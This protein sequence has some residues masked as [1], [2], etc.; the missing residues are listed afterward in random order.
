MGKWHPFE[1]IRT[2]LMNNPPVVVFFLCMVLMAAAFIGFGAYTKKHD[3]RDP[4]VTQVSSVY[5]FLHIHVRE[6]CN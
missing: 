6:Q 4:D 5:L 2:I 3:V 1:N